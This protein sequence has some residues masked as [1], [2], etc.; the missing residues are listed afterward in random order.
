MT[1]QEIADKLRET[2]QS[3]SQEDVDWA[4]VTED[5]QI[6]DLGFDSLS[7]LD[8]VYDVQQSFNLEFGAE[9]LIQVRSVADLVTFIETR[10]GQHNTNA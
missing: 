3:S 5:A 6:A 9:E 4:N 7:I 1:R 10:I 8:L 2:M